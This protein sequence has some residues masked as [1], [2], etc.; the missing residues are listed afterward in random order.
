[1]LHFILE[2]SSSTLENSKNQILS[3]C[4]IKENMGAI[5][6]GKPLRIYKIGL[7][8]QMA[9]KSTLLQFIVSHNHHSCSYLMDNRLDVF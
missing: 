4:I 9:Q 3:E 6:L 7:S 1:M 5:L 8:L 2:L